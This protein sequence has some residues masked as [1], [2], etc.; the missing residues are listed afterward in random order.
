MNIPTKL[1]RSLSKQLVLIT[2]DKQ[3]A[4]SSLKRHPGS[5]AGNSKPQRS[6]YTSCEDEI[7]YS[8]VSA[9]AH[10]STFSTSPHSSTPNIQSSATPMT[11]RASTSE[12]HNPASSPIV[13]HH[14]A[15]PIP[16]RYPH[17][18]AEFYK[19]QS[20]REVR[21]LGTVTMSVQFGFEI[22]EVKGMG[23]KFTEEQ[24]RA[25]K[26]EVLRWAKEIMDRCG[27][28]EKSWAWEVPS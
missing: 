8:S 13:F 16:K 6:S 21:V 2:E 4:A 11:D 14:V 12:G 7:T 22:E 3:S 26:E 28:D 17:I 1:V 24:Q 25:I 9:F 20:S 10:T 27:E 5:M 15:S 19:S 18:R 23:V